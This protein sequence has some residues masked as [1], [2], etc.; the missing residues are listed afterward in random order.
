VS[1]EEAYHRVRL[2]LENWRSPEGA[3]LSPWE[4]DDILANVVA[5]GHA[6]LD[7]A[8]DGHFEPAGRCEWCICKRRLATCLDA[9]IAPAT[10]GQKE[11]TE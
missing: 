11:S 8:I 10:G 3:C 5:F 7:D 4:V 1:I 2:R 9:L 6:V